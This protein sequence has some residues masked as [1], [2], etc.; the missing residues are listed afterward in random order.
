MET[1]KSLRT[2]KLIGIKTPIR[3]LFF[4]GFGILSGILWLLSFTVESDIFIRFGNWFLFFQFLFVFIYPLLWVTL[5]SKNREK[6][7]LCGP[8]ILF[9]IAGGIAGLIISLF[10][11]ILLLLG[12]G[13]FQLIKLIF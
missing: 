5:N 8:D 2:V 4:L 9:Y 13:L 10:I 12:V 7:M 1:I 11:E 3:F 6:A